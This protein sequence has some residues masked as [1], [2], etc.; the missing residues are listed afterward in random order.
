MSLL[1]VLMTKVISLP[2][3]ELAKSIAAEVVS[4]Y[5]EHYNL[6]LKVS[7]P[8]EAVKSFSGVDVI[9]EE[10]EEPHKTKHLNNEQPHQIDIREFANLTD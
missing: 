8:E 10:D 5:K 2:E 6:D 3:Q 7:L 4:I 1:T 9:T